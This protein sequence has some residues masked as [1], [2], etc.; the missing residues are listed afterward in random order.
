MFAAA[1]VPPLNHLLGQAEWARRRL[2]PHA[3]QVV[4]LQLPLA[5]V[6]LAVSEDGYLVRDTGDHPPELVLSIPAEAAMAV[7]SGPD[8]AMKNVRIAGNAEFG[9]ALGF[10]LRHLEWDAEADLARVLGDVAA[11]RLLR[12]L[13][14]AMAW[15]R[16]AL[17]RGADNLRD[18]LVAERPTLLAADALEQF[19]AELTALRDD[20]ARLDKRIAKLETR[21]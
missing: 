18:F 20:L 8:A 5:A 11:P 17:R 2:L 7:L 4:E 6:R 19:A 14:A 9:E 12:G 3:G 10:V 15:Q 13:G 16:D 1:L 21:G